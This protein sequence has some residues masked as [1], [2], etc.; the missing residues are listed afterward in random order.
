MSPVKCLL[1]IFMGQP[2]PTDN[3]PW[4]NL[5]RL[6]D[7]PSAK[8][9][10]R[11]AKILKSMGV[12]EGQIERMK[13]KSIRFIVGDMLAYQ[14]VQLSNLKNTDEIE[15]IRE[16]AT[17]VLQAVRTRV[18]VMA[19]KMSN[20][21]SIFP[22]G[23]EVIDWMQENSITEFLPIFAK[24]DLNS[25]LLISK[26]DRQDAIDLFEEYSQMF[27]LKSKKPVKG[28]LMRLNYA[29]DSLTNDPRTKSLTK[30]L[31]TFT[32]TNGSVLTVMFSKNSVE[33]MFSDTPGARLV[34]ISSCLLLLI[35]LV[36]NQGLSPLLWHD[37]LS[38]D[39]DS[40]KNFKRA[41]YSFWINYFGYSIP[42]V[43]YVATV[44][45][46]LI[47][48]ARLRWTLPAKH[49]FF[50]RS[51]FLIA[52]TAFPGKA[53]FN[54]CGLYYDFYA[55]QD[56]CYNGKAAHFAT[57]NYSEALTREHWFH[58]P[59]HDQLNNCTYLTTSDPPGIFDSQ[60]K[61]D[62]LNT[63][64][65]LLGLGCHVSTVMLYYRQE[66]AFL[67]YSLVMAVMF[68]FYIFRSGGGIQPVYA[69]F[70]FTISLM[71]VSIILAKVC[72]PSLQFYC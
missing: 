32:D 21:V 44:F 30:R 35:A 37:V 66:Y 4:D 61:L 15:T 54:W 67:S 56:D 28:N 33:A 72:R 43:L 53:I 20:F 42:L 2:R 47:A 16:C 34:S 29:L 12:D 68:F 50:A 58:D 18:S 9:A 17:R 23:H 11:A 5:R 31:E 70:T 27:N 13:A 6:S 48:G 59:F 40:I 19:S 25:L 10:N 45:I 62:S 63:E 3:F 71:S 14:G 46:M 22:N 38:L 36:F 60:A 7:T 51:Y 55:A 69:T 24:H 39:F 64:Y 8:T 65:S 26:I 1:P 57:L 49:I 52:V 41:E